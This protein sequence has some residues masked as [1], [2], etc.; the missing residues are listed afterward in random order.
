MTTSVPKAPPVTLIIFGAT[1]DLTR[2]LL[3]PALINMTRAGLVGSD[4]HVLGV[5]IEPGDAEMLRKHL[6]DFVPEKG[7]E[8]ATKR[9]AAWK[10]LR[11]RIDYLAG[12]FTKDELYD[13][14][15]KRI[16]AAPSD[17]VA[18]YLATQPSFFGPIVDKLADHGLLDREARRLPPRRDRKAVRHRSQIRAGAQQAHPGARRASSN[19]TG[20]TISSARRRCRTS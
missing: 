12:D 16:D 19:S 4:F 8:G 1:G 11:S 3:T 10:Q 9:G 2:R 20:S 6:E 18:F 13:E 5:S 17:N 7:G 15:A 14:L